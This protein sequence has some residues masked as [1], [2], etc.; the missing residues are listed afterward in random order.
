MLVHGFI[1]FECIGVEFKF[2][3]NS[4]F[5]WFRNRKER[6]NRNRKPNPAQETQPT[7][8]PGPRQTQAQFVSPLGPAST[9]T[10][11]P[12]S[13]SSPARSPPAWPGSARPTLRPV[14]ARSPRG[15]AP[16]PLTRTAWARTSARPRV[17]RIARSARSQCAPPMT[18]GPHLPASSPQ[19][20]A[21]AIDPAIP[22]RRPTKLR[23][24]RRDRRASPF[25]P[26]SGPPYPIHPTGRRKP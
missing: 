7:P 13:L 12:S 22:A 25:K 23:R 8:D 15:P 18:R 14:S 19:H 24:G 17:A 20:S 9:R 26:P 21:L 10:T 5:D 3:L 4:N 11:R 1:L 2:C 6:E 16:H